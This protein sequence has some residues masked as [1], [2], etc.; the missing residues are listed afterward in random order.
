MGMTVRSKEGDRFQTEYRR[1]RDEIDDEVV[2]VANLL[3]L[4]ARIAVDVSSLE[5]D[6]FF[7]LTTVDQSDR[8]V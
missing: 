2:D 4:A 8:G 6:S 1:L 7:D 3:K 5:K